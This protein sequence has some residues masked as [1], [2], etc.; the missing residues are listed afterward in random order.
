MFIELTDHLRCIA[1]HDEQFVLLLPDR[2]DGRRVMA[3]TV[4]CPV[5]GATVSVVEGAMDF[6]GP[7]PPPSSPTGLSVEA[8]ITLLGLEGPGGFIA[9]LG[10][11]AGLAVVLSGRVSPQG[12]H[13]PPSCNSTGA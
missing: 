13:E 9:L 3:G 2:M 4:G 1:G 7:P 6:G 10:A 12:S 8:I 5:C 11:A